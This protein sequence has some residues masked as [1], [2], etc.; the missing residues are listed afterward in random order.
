VEQLATTIFQWHPHFTDPRVDSPWVDIC[1]NLVQFADEWLTAG[2]V[3][4]YHERR[5]IAGGLWRCVLLKLR[6]WQVTLLCCRNDCHGVWLFYW[7]H[8]AQ[9]KAPVFKHLV[10]R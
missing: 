4:T 10:W 2:D 3:T 6:R 1:P 8:C 9:R 7:Q 5:N